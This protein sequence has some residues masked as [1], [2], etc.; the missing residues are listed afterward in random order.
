MFW[1]AGEQLVL[2][3][4]AYANC[5]DGVTLAYWLIN[6]AYP[7]EISSSDRIVESQE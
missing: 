7:D 1:T 6:D 3:C 2:H 5:E 4:D